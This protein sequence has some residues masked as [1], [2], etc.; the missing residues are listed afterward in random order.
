MVTSYSG[1]SKILNI[2]TSLICILYCVQLTDCV[3]AVVQ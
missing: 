3:N 1:Q 2:H